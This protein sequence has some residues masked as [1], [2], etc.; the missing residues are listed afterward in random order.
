MRCDRQRLEDIL[1]AIERIEKYIETE[2]S[3]AGGLSASVMIE[4]LASE[5]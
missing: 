3:G 1:E 4:T 5:Q 2:R